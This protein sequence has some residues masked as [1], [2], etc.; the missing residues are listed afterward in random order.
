MR[1]I[2]LEYRYQLAKNTRL[3]IGAVKCDFTG[4]AFKS[5]AGAA[6]VS[7]GRG[8]NNEFD[9]QMVWTELYGKF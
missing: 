2:T 8:F 9:Y 1:I 3:R 6:S 7:A 5:V 4:D